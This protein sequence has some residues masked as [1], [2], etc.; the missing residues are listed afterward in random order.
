MP[1]VRFVQADGS[2]QVVDV[3]VGRDLKQA[4]LDDLV[5]GIT[6]DCGGFAS[7]GTCHAYVSPEFAGRIPPPSV[8]EADMLDG[9]LG[10]VTA[11]D[12]SLEA[13]AQ[14]TFVED[15]EQQVEQHRFTLVEGAD[16][17]LLMDVDVIA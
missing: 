12:G 2:E 1:A 7:C 8:D 13:T 3:P 4:A 14:V 5:P 9:M 15:G 17:T 16:G 10:P 11:T 6:G